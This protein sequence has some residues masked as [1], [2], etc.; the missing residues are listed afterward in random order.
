MPTRLI[1]SFALL[2]RVVAFGGSNDLAKVPVGDSQGGH[3]EAFVRFVNRDTPIK[4]IVYEIDGQGFQHNG[5]H[6]IG[7]PSFEA[8]IQTNTFYI[9]SLKRIVD[10]KVSDTP[11][12]R[13]CGVSFSRAWLVDQEVKRCSTTTNYHSDPDPVAHDVRFQEQLSLQIFTLG[14]SQV[15]EV[16]SIELLG[17]TRMQGRRRSGQPIP[18]N[19]ELDDIGRVNK[20]TYEVF[21]NGLRLGQT[22]IYAYQDGDR[23]TWLPATVVTES[24]ETGR[25]IKREW[26]STNSI[27]QCEVGVTDV[28]SGGYEP[29]LFLGGGGKPKFTLYPIGITG[30]WVLLG[31]MLLVT[32]VFCFVV[33][34]KGK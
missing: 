19:V 13:A 34:R 29:E 10:G 16:G 32:S 26:K 2:V 21:G 8:S 20:L 28:G 14:L 22:Q 18:I 33:L 30:G 6:I 1:V 12:A 31:L 15:F 23:P 17:G 5:N 11:T 3:L 27:S 4:H 9:R 7:R 25:S 24:L